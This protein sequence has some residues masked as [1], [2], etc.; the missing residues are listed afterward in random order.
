MD[1][2]L[3]CFRPFGLKG[4]GFCLPWVGVLFLSLSRVASG[5]VIDFSG[6]IDGSGTVWNNT[7]NWSGGVLPVAADT[8][9]FGAAGTATS[10]GLT[11]SVSVNRITLDTT[12]TID[13]TLGSASATALTLTLAGT[14]VMLENL[15]TD[16]RTLTIAPTVNGGTGALTLSNP[17]GG[18]TVTATGDIHIGAVISGQGFTKAGSGTLTLSGANTF[19]GSMAVTG[20]TLRVGDGG[21]SGSLN[22]TTLALSASTQLVFD[23]SDNLTQ[24]VEISG[25]GSVVK[26]GAGTLTLTS[27]YHSY[28]GPTS[29]NEGT[30]LITG[31]LGLSPTTF[32]IA[33]GAKFAVQSASS[34]NLTQA[35]SGSGTFEK[36]GAGNTSVSNANTAFTG[37]VSVTAGTLTLNSMSGSTHS[38]PNA[39]SIDLAS[40]SALALGGGAGYTLSAPVSGAGAVNHTGANTVTLGNNANSFT[41]RSSVSGG[42]VLNVPLIA[43]AGVASSIGA[44]LA[45]AA[46]LV[47][48]SGTLRY[49]G[50]AASTDRL[51]SIGT[52]STVA[53]EA[54]GSGAVSFTN[55]GSLGGNSQTGA[56]TFTLSGTSTAANSVAAL[57]PDFSGATTVQ[58]TGTG[59]WALT[60][61]ASTYTGVTRVIDGG[62][63]IVTKLANG[64]EA[65]SIGASTSAAANLRLANNSTL[66]YEG[67]GDSTDRLFSFGATGGKIDASG[68]G[69]LVFTNTG[70]YANDGNV[71]ARTLTLTGSNTGDNTMG[72]LLANTGNANALVKEGAGKWVL[73]NNNTYTGATTI[74]AGTLQL[75]NGGSSGSLGSANVTNNAVLAMNRSDTLTMSQVISGSG[76]L[77][78]EG[79]G[80]TVLTGASTYTGATTISAGTLQ[81]GNGGTTGSIAGAGGITNNGTLA[82]HRS[83]DLNWGLTMSGSGGLTKLGTNTLT[84]TSNPTHT[85]PTVVQ[86]GRLRSNV[87]FAMPNSSFTVASGAT[88]T[89]ASGGASIGAL[90]GAGTV[91]NG[92][93]GSTAASFTLGGGNASGTFTGLMRDGGTAP[94]ALVKTGS[95]MQAM[96]GANTFSGTVT[97]N[98]GTLSTTDLANGGSAS[99]IGTSSS[100]AAS[101]TLDG[102][103]LGYTGSGATTNRRFTLGSAGGGLDASGTGAV[104]FSDNS[105]ISFSGAASARTLSLGGTNTDANTLSA[106]IVD[107]S[108]A[109]SVVKNGPGTWLLTHN[110][111]YTGGT[112]LNDGVLRI[113]SSNAI[114]NG[115]VTFAGGVLETTQSMAIGN[116]VIVNDASNG[117]RV[118]TGTLNLNGSISGSFPLYKEGAGTLIIAG[119]SNSV[120]TVVQNGTVQGSAQNAGVSISLTNPSSVFEFNQS[121]S[122]SYGGVISGNGSIVVSGSG[123]LTLTAANTF[124]GETV[125]S[126]SSVLTVV[127]NG[128]LGNASGGVNVQNGASVRLQDGID[129]GAEPITLNGGGASSQNGALVSANGT[130]TISGTV[131]AATNASVAALPGSTLNLGGGLIKNGTTATLTGGGNIVIGGSGITGSLANSDL[132]VD[133]SGTV[134]TLTTTNSYNGPTTIQNAAKLVLGISNA[135]PTTPRTDL[136]VQSSGTFDLAGQTDA[137]QSLAGDSTGILKNSSVGGTSTLEIAQP[138]GTAV[139]NGVI[140]GTSGG[141]QGNIALVK[142]GAGTQVL[143]GANTYSGSTTIN[144]GTLQIGNGGS[145]GTLGS[146]AI[147]NDGEFK[148]NRSGTLTLAQSFSGSGTFTQA[149]GGTTILTGNSSTTGGTTILSGTLRMGNGGLNGS[150]GSGA[151]VNDGTLEIKR[152]NN[153]TLS[154]PMSGSG[155]LMQSGPGHTTLTSNSNTFSGGTVI[156]NGTLVAANTT[157]GTSAT[158][159]GTVE[160][161]NSA[162]LAGSGRIAGDVTF[163]TG[164]T[165]LIG[166]VSGDTSGQDFEFAGSLTSTGTM[167]AR[168]DLFSNA[169]V[170]TLNSSIS[171]ADRLVLAGGD[172]LIDMDLALFL[173]DPNSLMNWAVGDAWQII[174][175]GSV[176]SGN[177]QITVS[178]LTAPTL[179]LGYVWDTSSLNAT[180]QIFI[181]VPEPSRGMLLLGG[182][183]LLI[184]R[185]RRKMGTTLL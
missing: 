100:A 76:S 183:C 115:P 50:A 111:T 22:V 98:G 17:N 21:T 180:G 137:V 33:P 93:T 173:G 35:L 92:A 72:L 94:L 136:T 7:V 113:S 160:V 169:G 122:G 25:A 89:T 62:T 69:P 24:A 168:F 155:M 133:G 55:T 172:R 28:S 87:G 96:N 54:A 184:T 39:T 176:S 27:P 120:P 161:Q 67:A 5:A 36:S 58:K 84:L 163:Y 159:S 103:A 65:S 15:N 45:D 110:N 132:V 175:W 125:V 8:A 121:T 105:P 23:R 185:R 150:I 78:Q 2:A 37:A 134:V 131:T 13:R 32:V 145:T 102:G 44:A 107:S 141:T 179:P 130:N 10:I 181:A 19:S 26:E 126:G 91:E 57:I 108:E 154:Q 117:V 153:I 11:S 41:G 104:V 101:L 139:F 85:G 49:T 16:G 3:P 123:G 61:T 146:G 56:R 97:I 77:R 75:G 129:I 73:T 70:A 116:D 81:L 147:V 149:G 177:R 9:R 138:S 34:V 167:N 18:R 79:S 178:S 171:A 53:L 143:A 128:A 14:G 42:G 148:V 166:N 1:P 80:T 156:T 170:G 46:N 31:Q 90:N 30:L 112:T 38:L 48:A 144:G 43:N 127:T 114:G 86:A 6:G 158:G 4:N 68:T 71:V 119:S 20:G 74:S 151:V 47:I 95:G 164:A 59:T 140:E 162:R 135:L 60:G 52:G 182:L 82:I 174:H 142:S 83:D 64:G 152:S 109:T 51:F 124:A 88:M 106:R 118:T 99:G 40:G 66:R 165:F 29:I 63:L 12:T 157:A